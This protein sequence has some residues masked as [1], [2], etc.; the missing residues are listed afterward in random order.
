MDDK[1]TFLSDCKQFG[2]QLND[3]REAIWKLHLFP[4]PPEI[5]GLTPISLLL[6]SPLPKLCTK[7][8]LVQPIS[9]I[10]N[11]NGGYQIKKSVTDIEQFAQR[12]NTRGKRTY[13]CTYT[14][15]SYSAVLHSTTLSHIRKEHFGSTDV[16]SKHSQKTVSDG[17]VKVALLQAEIC[18]SNSRAFYVHKTKHRS[19]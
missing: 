9:I 15:C 13:D 3:V 7:K 18:A 17:M 5:P 12:N 11:A 8:Y 4:D 10:R 6:K 14:D 19:F 1:Q 16:A 2:V